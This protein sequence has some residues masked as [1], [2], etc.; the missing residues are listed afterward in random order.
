M[1]YPA[2]VLVPHTETGLY[3]ETERAVER[4]THGACFELTPRLNPFAYA[5]ILRAHWRVPGDLVIVEQDVVPPPGSIY[6]LVSCTEPWCSLLVW[7]GNG[8]IAT[9][10]G[11]CKLGHELRA[12]MPYLA[13]A[14]YGK[15]D[16]RYWTR[17]GW[18][19]I[20]H[21]C[22]VEVLNSAGRTAT[23][24]LD[25]GML[26]RTHS[27]QL[28][29]STCDFLSVDSALFAELQAR[30]I[31]VHTHMEIATHLHDYDANPVGSLLPWHQRP[32]DPREWPAR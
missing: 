27:L 24:R 9:S 12:V 23:L 7:Y 26:G 3:H 29:P 21:D 8:Y 22:S 31:H 2:V 1:R 10:F 17:R 15:P 25:S 6:R 16:S 14:V 5:D 30:N 4:Q 13:D 18:T 28:R 20:P 11:C 32:Y 19:D